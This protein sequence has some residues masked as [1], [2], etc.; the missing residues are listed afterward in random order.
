MPPPDETGTNTCNGTDT[1]TCNDDADVVPGEQ[2]LKDVTAELLARRGA[3]YGRDGALGSG[4]GDLGGTEI[5]GLHRGVG[6]DLGGCAAGNHLSEVEH[7][8]VA[9]DLHDEI[10]VVFDEQHGEAVRGE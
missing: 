4:S 5:R 1:D 9:A 2:T 7:I 6:L 10:H 8:D 3:M